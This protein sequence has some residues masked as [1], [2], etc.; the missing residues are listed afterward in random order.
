MIRATVSGTEDYTVELVF[1]PS[2][3]S[4]SCTCPYHR[5]R[6]EPCK[7]IWAMILKA[8]EKGYFRG[9]SEDF[10]FGLESSSFHASSG[11]P[12]LR[13]KK[14][15]SD[16]PQPN[17]RNDLERIERATESESRLDGT[18]WPPGRELFYVLDV[19]DTLRKGKP[20]LHL[21]FRDRKKDGSRG[22]LRSRNIS[23]KDLSLVPDARH[24]YMLAMLREL[25]IKQLHDSFRYFSSTTDSVLSDYWLDI[26]MYLLLL[27]RMCETGSFC[28]KLTEGAGFD[29]VPV[30]W[31][32]GPPWEFCLELRGAGGGDYELTGFLRR[33]EEHMGLSTPYLLLAGGLVFTQGDAALLEDFDSFPWISI[34]RTK[35]RITVAEKQLL[36]LFA[37]IL[38]MK[39]VP[40][41]M[42]P[43]G[44][45]FRTE[46]IKPLR[47]LTV[48][49]DPKGYPTGRSGLVGELSFDYNGRILGREDIGVG[50]YSKDEKLLV[51]RDPKE[52]QAALDR[53]FALGFRQVSSFYTDDVRLKLAA[54]RLPAV[55][56]GLLE[57][58]WYVEAEGIRYRRGGVFNIEVSSGIDW[59]EV[60]GSIRFEEQEVVLPE[61]LKALRRGENKVRLGD[62]TYGVLPQDWLKQYGLLAGFGK[63]QKDHVRFRS[64][65]AGLLDLLLEGQPHVS[66]DETFR[67]F[68]RRLNGF[69]KVK[70]LDPSPGFSGKLRGY[71]R[72]G[73]GWFRFLDT[74]GFGGCLADD[75]GLGKTVQVLALLDARREEQSGSTRRT[76]TPGEQAS[77]DDRC[78][79]LIVVPKTIVFNW[80][81]EAC[82][83]TPKLK[84]LDYTGPG[85]IKDRGQ[86][87][88]YDVIL[89]TYGTMRND[90]VHLKDFHFD[91]IVLDEAQVVKNS[92]TVASKAVRL[93]TGRLRLSL[94]GTPIENHLG[95][96]WSLFEFL[97]PG[98]LGGVSVFQKSL[99]S[100]RD[101]DEQTIST[102]ARAIRPF[103]LRRTKDQV[104]TDLP[105]KMEQTL[106]CELGPWERKRYNELRDFYRLSLQKQIGREGLNRAKIQVLEA[107]L[108]LRQAACHTGLIDKTVISRSSAKVEVLLE[109]LDDVLAGGRK[110]LVFSQ[111]TSLLAIVRDKLD[112]RKTIYEYLDGQTRNRAEKV[113]RFQSDPDCR[114]FLIS[115]KAGGLGLNLTAAE[116]VFLLDPWWNPAVEAQAI[117]RTHRIGQS[118]K[119]FAYRLIARDTVEEKVLELQKSKRK[120][121]ESII[122][123][124]NR[125]IGNL[126]REDLE[127]LLS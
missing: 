23:V 123:A 106:Y 62:G 98:M 16:A 37:K 61:L 17:W 75:M 82:R 32:N 96:L 19:P 85:R 93:L 118:R 116:Y 13:S 90:I 28:L 59:F 27:P 119:I 126:S 124:D 30:A 127:L 58:G 68:R 43:E 104:A 71:Q 26:E 112:G 51:F 89:T 2:G 49:K 74:F 94:S 117:D 22:A 111:F 122:T 21:Y 76:S 110:A 103:I 6:D 56:A 34:L 67:Q 33:G 113:Q 12:S 48:R 80:K 9:I 84:V 24:R 40:P 25:S 95:E 60:R 73:L 64:C 88:G 87:R 101:F 35:K 77:P 81:Q 4:L 65:Q 108:R 54:G 15:S 1:L 55:V 114:L 120:L 7:H 20:L 66:C 36:E 125:F 52:E 47:R 109:H 50:F 70:P 105:D 18:S 8:E 107:L 92:R 115:L 63:E 38:S 29:P 44:L 5:D 31:D 69:S 78:P 72:E 99:G 11:R 121:A 97:N 79:S 41:L 83:F 45:E 100:R 10:L 53:L 14:V 102:L 39:R 3:L 57:E 46:R 86:F 42:L 91:Y